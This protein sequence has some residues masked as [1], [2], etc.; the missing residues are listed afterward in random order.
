MKELEAKLG[1][2]AVK[3]LKTVARYLQTL[4]DL[5][6]EYLFSH[7]DELLCVKHKLHPIALQQDPR[8]PPIKLSEGEFVHPVN[9]FLQQQ[10]M[11]KLWA[12][13]Q[14]LSLGGGGDSSAADA[15]AAKA[16]AAQQK[17]AEAKPVV[18]EKKNFDV[19]LKGYAAADKVKI[20][21]ELKNILNLGLKEVGPGSVGKRQS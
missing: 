3:K 17:A 20:I 1:P 11:E 10:G 13:K 18:E 9:Y 5:E 21:K 7:H 4:S 8:F 12:S 15:E 2:D 19:L 14:G 6:E 16:Q